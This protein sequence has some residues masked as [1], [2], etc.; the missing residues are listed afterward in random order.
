MP[1]VQRDGGLEA[2]KEKKPR[3]TGQ[4][5]SQASRS[6]ASKTKPKTKTKAKTQVQEKAIPRL[7]QLYKDEIVPSLMKEFKFQSP[8]EV[9]R[10]KKVVLNVSLGEALT[11]S[12]AI[13]SAVRDLTT[14]T[15]QKPVVTRARK[16]IAGFKLRAG[17]AIGT[18]VTLRGRRM[19]YFLERLFNAALPRIRDFNGIP[20]SSFDGQGNF[21][22]G[23]REQIIFPEID[24]D[25]I[26]RIRG[27]QVTIATTA[28]DDRQAERLLE[29]MGVPFARQN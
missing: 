28:K 8:M 29:M 1:E 9:P 24:Y 25:S 4:A 10:I 2:K 16:S 27:F 17:V 18:A 26:D 20:R 11:N 13:E 6:A 21:T 3:R 12:R 5:K 7:T 19:M 22:I 14:M 23:I 15:G